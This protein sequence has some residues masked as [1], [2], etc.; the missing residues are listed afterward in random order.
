MFNPQR[1]LSRFLRRINFVET[2]KAAG[3]QPRRL[4]SEQVIPAKKIPKTILDA[5]KKSNEMAKVN[6]IHHKMQH[7]KTDRRNV[8]PDIL[9]FYLKFTK[10]LASRGMPYY[11]HCFYRSGNEQNKLKSRGVSRASAGHS[12]HQFHAAV[13]IVH[14]FDHWDRPEKEWM[15]IGTIGIEIARKLNLK[16]VWGGDWDGDGD[17]YDNQLFDPAHWELKHWRDIRAL[18]DHSL[19]RANGSEK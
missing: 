18:Q 11:A 5:S 8:H 9:E 14:S 19:D 3:V 13:D 12:A 16:I 6:S 15:L 4:S 2:K 1:L 17:F 7:I 10:E